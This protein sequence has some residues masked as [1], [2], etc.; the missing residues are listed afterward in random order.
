[1][2]FDLSSPGR[3]TVIRIVYGVLA[4]LFL[5]GFVGF[6]IG[7]ELGGGGIIDSITGNGGDGD[8]AEQY[9]EQIEDA[10]ARLETDP[11]DDRALASLVQYRFLSGS[12]QVETDEAGRPVGLTEE[13]RAEF[14]SAVEVWG[15]Y[16]DADPRRIDDTAAAYAVQAFAFL[17]DAGGAAAAQELVAEAEPGTNNYFLLAQ[18]RYADGDFKGGDEAADLAIE[19]APADQRKQ[20]EKALDEIRATAQ[21]VEKQ[22]EKAAEAGDGGGQ[23]ESPFGGL[24]SEGG[25]PP[26]AP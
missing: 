15:R 18:Y 21:K 11:Q 23:L 13:S 14:E 17:G 12:A 22:T 2:L 9:Q 16:V 25:V 1:M 7:G 8:T 4:A 10:E 6:G 3:K 20:V 19:E 5:V 24:G 26:T